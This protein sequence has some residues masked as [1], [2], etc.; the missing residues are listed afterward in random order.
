MHRS[1]RKPFDR[2]AE[3]VSRV[4]SGGAFFGLAVLL[5]VLWVPTV[6]LFNSVDTWQLVI[7]TITS[8]LAFLLVALLQNSDRRQDEA[9]HAKL[10]VLAAAVAELLE[11]QCGGREAERI[12]ALRA[13]IGL[14]E[15][16]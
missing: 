3:A 5:V 1:S 2:F 16:V 10:N 9:M 12:E 13:A 4:V 6:L 7:S 15:R 8:V 14:E 11:E